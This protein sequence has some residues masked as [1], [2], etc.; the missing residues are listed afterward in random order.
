MLQSSGQI[1]MYEDKYIKFYHS[2]AWKLARKQALA[3]DHYLCQEC[4]RQGIVRTANT[5]HHI[6][7]IK[8]DFNKRLNLGLC[9]ELSIGVQKDRAK[10]VEL[11]RKAAEQGD[12]DARK[13]LAKLT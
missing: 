1:N 8:D 7:P 10:A 9:Y 11:Y 12:A 3:R 2:K 13:R 5:V 4:L 6:V